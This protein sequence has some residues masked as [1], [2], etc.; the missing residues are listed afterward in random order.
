MSAVCAVRTTSNSVLMKSRVNVRL[1]AL[2]ATGLVPLMSLSCSLPLASQPNLFW[3]AVGF[4]PQG[5]E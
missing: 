5:A 1:S 2:S 3:V 4:L